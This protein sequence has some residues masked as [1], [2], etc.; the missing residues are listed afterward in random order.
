MKSGTTLRQGAKADPLLPVTSIQPWIRV[1]GP[2]WWFAAVVLNAC[3]SGGS[4]PV[5]PRVIATIAVSPSGLMLEALGATAQLESTARDQNGDTISA[6][7]TWGSSDS[8]IATVDADGLVTAVNIGTATVT[9]RSGTVSNSV[10]VTVEQR[11]ASI[12]LSLDE[13]VLIGETIF[14]AGRPGEA[15]QS[16]ARDRKAKPPA[17]VTGADDGSGCLVF[18]G[19]WLSVRIRVG[20]L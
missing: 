12:T 10:N 16:Q 11:P 17:R 20:K 8:A 15:E 9:V 7:V 18:I 1:T 19:I 13:A 2:A 5:A 14:K 6:Q 3:G 4:D